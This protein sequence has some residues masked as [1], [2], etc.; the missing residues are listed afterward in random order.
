MGRAAT[1]T[2]SNLK[3]KAIKSTASTT[4]LKKKPNKS[5]SGTTKQQQQPPPPKAAVASVA[6]NVGKS[7]DIVISK[8]SKSKHAGKLGVKLVEGS[9]KKKW[10][11]LLDG[12]DKPTLILKKLVHRR[13]EKWDYAEDVAKLFENAEDDDDD[14]MVDMENELPPPPYICPSCQY[15]N[16]FDARVCRN[17]TCKQTRVFGGWGGCFGHL[18]QTWTCPECTQPNTTTVN[19]CITCNTI[20]P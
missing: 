18:Q 8:H 20:R 16:P 11:V 9:T 13:Q 19:Q 3:P 15:S 6:V 4:T 17:K 7:Y 5:N 1:L 14:T 2:S 12:D 10:M